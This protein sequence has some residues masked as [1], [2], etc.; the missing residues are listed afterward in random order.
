MIVH[1]LSAYIFKF[2]SNKKQYIHR[3]GN[4]FTTNDKRLARL[5]KLE[6]VVLC[7]QINSHIFTHI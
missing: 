3:Y 6:S 7:Q 2:S 1:L 5:G 4:V